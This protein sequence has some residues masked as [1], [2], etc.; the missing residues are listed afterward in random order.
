MLTRDH[1]H[2]AVLDLGH[3]TMK[4]AV[5]AYANG[6]L[7]QLEVL[8]PR[9]SP[10]RSDVK[11][12]VVEV[13]ADTLAGAPSDVAPTVVVSLASY[14]SPNGQPEDSHSLYAPLRTLA[15][16]ELLHRVRQR[17]G[18]RV[19]RVRFA[20]DGTLA[21]AGVQSASPAAAVIMLGT[22]L[23]VGFVPPADELRPVAADFKVHCSQDRSA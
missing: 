9:P 14:V 7:V 12:A 15:P 19:E 20:H 11:T 3:T 17:S 2:A 8:E 13:I 10:L 22:A 23:G 1:P 18:R 16:V 21:G 6:T 4:R 5:A